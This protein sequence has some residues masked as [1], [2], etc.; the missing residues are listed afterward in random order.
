[1]DCGGRLK[2]NGFPPGDYVMRLIV[3]DV[4]AKSKYSRAE[5]WMDFS[6]R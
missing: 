3:T 1:L 5:Q 4:L 2:L 6:V